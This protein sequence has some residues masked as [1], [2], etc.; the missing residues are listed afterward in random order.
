M[1]R[2]GDFVIT[3]LVQADQEELQCIRILAFIKTAY[4]FKR[5]GL[6]LQ[7]LSQV[8]IKCLFQVGG[9]TDVG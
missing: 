8:I 1:R 4:P 2:P 9:K 5:L 6:I 3:S 7:G